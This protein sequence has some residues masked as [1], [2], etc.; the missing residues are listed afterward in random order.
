MTEFS[1]RD[2]EMALR[3]FSDFARDLA[4]ADHA[5]WHGCLK[6]LIHHCRTDPVMRLVADPLRTRADID[7]DAWYA[8]SL[9]SRS[10]QLP[11]DDDERLSLLFQILERIHDE[12][13]NLLGFAFHVLGAVGGHLDNTFAA[14]NEHF[15]RK[16][17][18]EVG[19][20]LEATLENVEDQETVSA[21]RITS[22]FI[23][24]DV[25]GSAVGPGASVVTNDVRALTAAVSVFPPELRDILVRAREAAE[26]ET[27]S[28][29]DK[30]DLLDEVTKL[31]TALKE[32]KPEAGRIRRYW[33][34]VKELAPTVASILSSAKVVAEL[35]A[36]GGRI[37]F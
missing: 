27:L 7:V 9:Q 13:F 34:R 17:A 26:A 29:A 24:G 4:Q 37:R 11:L 14:V 20:R 12:K 28:A 18:R 36:R 22:I 5:S 33:D 19:R 8:S 31:V 25:V 2:A 3:K 16:F 1:R 35:L 6:L 30:T 10:Y 23:G 32:P 15:V 21:E